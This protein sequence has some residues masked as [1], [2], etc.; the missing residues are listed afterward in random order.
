MSARDAQIMHPA[1]AVLRLPPQTPQARCL[2]E[3][4]AVLEP[5]VGSAAWYALEPPATRAEAG[6][7]VSAKT[8]A[9]VH[10]LMVAPLAA[11][12]LVLGVVSLRR[13]ERREPF[14]EDDL[15]LAQELAARAALSIDNARRYTQQQQA[16]LSLQR[17]TDEGGRGLFLVAQFTERWGT[18][19]TRDGKTVWTEQSLSGR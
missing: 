8:G 11:R 6:A 10:S 18:R 4:R 2:A 17:S 9:D 1:G 19:Y 15:T 5:A 13:S 12:G 3:R 16:A 7:A 14:E